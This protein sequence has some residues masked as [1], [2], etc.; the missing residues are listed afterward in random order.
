MEINALMAYGSAAR[1]VKLLWENEMLG[2]VM[3]NL[4]DYLNTVKYP[5]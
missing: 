1:S 2:F 3:P 4:A 5:R